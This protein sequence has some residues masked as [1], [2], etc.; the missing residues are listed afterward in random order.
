MPE[1]PDPATLW[2]HRRRLV[3]MSWFAFVAVLTASVALP[4]RVTTVEGI[5]QTGLWVL[6][7]HIIS[8]YGT[9]AIE[10]VAAMKKK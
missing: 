5:L 4:E 2:K 1:H 3:Y 7:L 6:G 8:Y 10:A 9:A